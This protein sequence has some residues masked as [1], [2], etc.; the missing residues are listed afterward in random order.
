MAVAEVLQVGA[1]PTEVGLCNGQ[2]P[3]RGSHP[4]S[5]LQSRSLN[6]IILHAPLAW[7]SLGLDSLGANCPYFSPR[8]APRG[9]GREVRSEM[10]KFSHGH[11]GRPPPSA[12]NAAILHSVPKPHVPTGGRG[13]A[14]N[15]KSFLRA[16]Y[17]LAKFT[18]T[19]VS[20]NKFHRRARAI[21]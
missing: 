7:L 18:G 10:L 6:L 3:E 12:R 17:C 9:S 4:A 15:C 11:E 5:P 20:R 1:V 21:T 2:S 19:N 14:A 16:P 8:R 13:A